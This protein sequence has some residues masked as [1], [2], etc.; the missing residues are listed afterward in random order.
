[1]IKV[2]IADDQT[3]FRAMLR[4]MLNQAD[5]IELVAAATNGLEAVELSVKHKPDVLLLDI[6]MPQK[7]GVEVLSELKERLPDT[8]IL[9]LTTFEDVE[10]IMAACN[11]RVD[12]YLIK[13]I[14]PDVLIMA[15]K[16]IHK[17]LV[18]F[19]ESIYTVISPANRTPYTT[20]SGKVEL[21]NII[22]DPVDIA[23]IRHVADGRTNKEIAYMLNYSEGTIKNRI[24]RI[25]SNTGLADRTEISVFAVKNGLI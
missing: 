15:V 4:E 21:G 1:M 8:K 6:K 3:L 24:S 9:M 18:L 20:N 12:G 14:E 19:H 25:L 23:V 16:C 10:N 17:G 11:L 22:F 2:L 7:T 13:D 5:D